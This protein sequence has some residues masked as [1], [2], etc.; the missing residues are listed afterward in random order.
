MGSSPIDALVRALRWR[1]Q[2]ERFVS[3]NATDSMACFQIYLARPKQ[4]TIRTG[5]TKRK[6]SLVELLPVC[7]DLKLPMK[8]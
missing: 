3:L 6:T 5:I 2:S 8:V 7:S 1:S 4:K